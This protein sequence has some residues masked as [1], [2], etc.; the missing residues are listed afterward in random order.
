LRLKSASLFGYTQSGKCSK[1][2]CNKLAKQ[3]APSQ[4]ST[5]TSDEEPPAASRTTNS[6]NSSN[7]D[8][9]ADR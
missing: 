9:E 4:T 6:N 7:D 5:S 3:A 1:F 2:V 8:S